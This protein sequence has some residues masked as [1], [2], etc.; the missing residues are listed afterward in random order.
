[1]PRYFAYGSNLKAS[2]LRER[3]GGFEIDGIGTLADH[4]LSFAKRGRDGSGKACCE[5]AAGE[6]VWGVLYRIEETQLAL[7]DGFEAGYRRAVV[8]ISRQDGSEVAAVTY[9]AVRF[10]PEPVPYEWYKLL[11]IDGAREHGLPADWQAFL[12]GCAAKPDPARR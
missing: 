12:A 9:H 3:V 6:R 2:R 8:T 1:V 5:A 11:L 10:T 7:L 4:R